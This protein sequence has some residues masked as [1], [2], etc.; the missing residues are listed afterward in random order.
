M[1]TL[2]VIALY[3]LAPAALVLATFWFVLY[4]TARKEAARKQR[5]P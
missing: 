5:K 2:K 3:Y 1:T 4:G